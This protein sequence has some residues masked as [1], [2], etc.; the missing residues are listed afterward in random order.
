MSRPF[1]VTALHGAV[2][3][4]HMKKNPVL[5]HQTADGP[6]PQEV[7]ILRMFQ[8]PV[9]NDSKRWEACIAGK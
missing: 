8:T 6:L 2:S 9:D 5:I 3:M 4:L 1:Q 7:G